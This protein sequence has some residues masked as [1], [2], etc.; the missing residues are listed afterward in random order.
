MSKENKSLL[1]TGLSEQEVETDI[2]RGVAR[3]RHIL[4]GDFAE[5]MIH[6]EEEVEACDMDVGEPAET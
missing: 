5:S 1:R 3:Q 2:N 4:F 6:A